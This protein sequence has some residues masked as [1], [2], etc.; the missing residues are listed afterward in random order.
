[1]DQFCFQKSEVLCQESL[2]R[3]EGP[4]EKIIQY[5]NDAM[6]EEFGPVALSWDAIYKCCSA[7]PTST[8]WNNVGTGNER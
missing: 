1:M 7:R 4:C 3:K 6:I 5:E 2:N 8:I